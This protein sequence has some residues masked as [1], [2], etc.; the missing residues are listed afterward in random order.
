MPNS[1]GLTFSAHRFIFWR[2]LVV[3]I[4]GGAIIVWLT[5]HSLLRSSAYDFIT[6]LPGTV[7]L[8]LLLAIVSHRFALERF[9]LRIQNNGLFLDDEWIALESIL[10]IRSDINPLLQFLEI[11]RS[12]ETIFTCSAL[13]FGKEGRDL[14]GLTK[15][16][17]S[18][19]RADGSHLPELS[20]RSIHD[21]AISKARPFIW[22]LVVMAIALDVIFLGLWVLG[23]TQFT[24]ILLVLNAP[25]LTLIPLLRKDPNI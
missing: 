6:L 2:F 14:R 5:I 10:G 22:L 15:A 12:N 16:I 4:L 7:A 19:R 13:S 11:K 25:L 1:L 20:Y 9:P 17:R 3:A 23:K 18:I 24:P 8:L 21:T